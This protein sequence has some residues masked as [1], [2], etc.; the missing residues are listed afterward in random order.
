MST[1]SQFDHIVNATD[2]TNLYQQGKKDNP[3]L[4]GETPSRILVRSLILNRK[5]IVLFEK[6]AMRLRS[7]LHMQ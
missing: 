3:R 2:M 6:T 1:D 5:Q 7:P 4:G